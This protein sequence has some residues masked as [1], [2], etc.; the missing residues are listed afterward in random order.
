MRTRLY[1]LESSRCA[2]KNVIYFVHVGEWIVYGCV[3]VRMCLFACVYA[4]EGIGV[5][6]HKRVYEPPIKEPEGGGD[7]AFT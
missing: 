4:Y 7:C 5:T 1:A 6:V 3:R 2:S